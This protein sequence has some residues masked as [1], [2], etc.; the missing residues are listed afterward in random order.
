MY[1]KKKHFKK[2]HENKFLKNNIK[3]ISYDLPWCQMFEPGMF[4]SLTSYLLT[5]A[6][7]Y[8][9]FWFDIYGRK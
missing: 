4:F 1:L 8:S 7:V 3:K 5:Q 9:M 2:Q 6:L